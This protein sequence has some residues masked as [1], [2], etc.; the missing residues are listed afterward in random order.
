MLHHNDDSEIWAL[1]ARSLSS[2]ATSAEE[3]QL[4]EL[5]KN[6][7]HLQ[8]QYELMQRLWQNDCL[9]QEYNSHIDENVNKILQQANFEEQKYP[10]HPFKLSSTQII[11]VAAVVL[12]VVA[13]LYIILSDFT[14]LKTP[15]YDHVLHT[16]KG[17]RSRHILPDGT[18]VWLNAGSQLQLNKNY[19]RTTRE[20]NLTGE[21][22][23]DVEHSSIPFIVQVYNL[24]LRVLGTSFNVKYYPNE[25]EVETT[26][27]KGKLEVSR[28]GTKKAVLKPNEKWVVKGID[29][30]D[31]RAKELLIKI[32][33]VDHPSKLKEIA[34]MYN[35]LEFRGEAFVELAEKLERWYNM[36]I[37]F[38]DQQ[39]QK[40][41]FNG[42]FEDETI[43]QAL[44][45]LQQVAQFNYTIKNHDIYISSP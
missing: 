23:F 27:V 14:P 24:K 34:W 19:N 20:V 44:Q 21:A 1:I 30:G 13:L 15:V 35:R 26:L 43:D 9:T 45:A 3:D 36:N 10:K 32:E 16:E 33:R 8:Q 37:H 2:E 18:V 31:E 22:F 40:L 38:N 41:S 39:V 4:Q 29:E 28:N 12:G 25:K 5:L 42:S 6:N 7:P 17:T 11:A